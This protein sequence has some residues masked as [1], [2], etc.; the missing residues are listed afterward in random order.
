MSPSQATL[1]SKGVTQATCKFTLQ[2]LT[3]LAQLATL[4]WRTAHDPGFSPG[5]WV[6][7]VA[8]DYHAIECPVLS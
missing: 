5:T 8:Q 2:R 3:T 7:L 4:A 1:H 6:T